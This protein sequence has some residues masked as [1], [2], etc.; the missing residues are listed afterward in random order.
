MLTLR[1]THIRASIR[2]CV[3]VCVCVCVCYML[4]NSFLGHVLASFSNDLVIF[5]NIIMCVCIYIYIY[6]YMCVCMC[7]LEHTHDV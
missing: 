1:Y 2:M 7:V 6:I 3:Y 4:Y 5:N